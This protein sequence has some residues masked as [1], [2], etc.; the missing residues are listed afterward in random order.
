MTRANDVTPV[1][2]LVRGRSGDEYVVEVFATVVTIR[3][4]G[5]R[6][7]KVRVCMEWGG[8]L[9][10]R[11]LVARLEEEA[12]AKRAARRRRIR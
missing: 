6:S 10:Q 9:F 3:P 11:A 4:K 8:S 5:S 1:R 7:P 12:R 2:R